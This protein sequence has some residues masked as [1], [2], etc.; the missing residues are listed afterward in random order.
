LRLAWA[1]QRIARH[2][3]PDN[4][5]GWR[6]SYL[7]G[8]QGNVADAVKCIHWQCDPDQ[9]KRKLTRLKKTLFPQDT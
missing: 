2:K 6:R 1:M 3:F 9:E 4:H 8:C 5:D 7:I